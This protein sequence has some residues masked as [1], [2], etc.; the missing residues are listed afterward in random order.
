MAEDIFNASIIIIDDDDELRET[1][2]DLLVS[3]GFKNAFQAE[4]GV[5]ALQMAKK[6]KFDLIVSDLNM[7]EM[8][9]IE[10]IKKIKEI[11]PKVI[12]MI[13][14]GFGNMD[15]AIKAFSE[16]HINDFLSKPVENDELLE[17]IKSHLSKMGGDS[18]EAGMSDMVR[19]E[20]GNQRNYFGQFLIDNGFIA[21]EDLLEALQKQ[22]DTGKM[23]GDTLVEMGLMTADSLVSALSEQKGYAIADDKAMSQISEDALKKVPMDYAR[24]H[25]LIPIA[26][27][28][29]GLKVAMVN[30]DDLAVTD[31]LKMIA[32]MSIIPV[33]S[34]KEKID[35][36]IDLFYKKLESTTSANS[37]LS[38]IFAEGDAGIEEVNIKDIKDEDNPDSAPII[39]LVNSILAKADLDGSSDIHIE[40]QEKYVQIRFRKDGDLYIPNGYERLPK[41]LQSS[42]AARIKVLT[43]TMKLDI[44]LRPQDGKIR[45]KLKGR[46]IDFRVGTLPTVHGEKIVL[47]LLKTEELYPIEDI[48]SKNSVFIELFIKNI[49][50]QDGI[51][52]V[53]GPTGSGKTNTLNSAVNYIKNVDI[54]IVEVADPVEIQNEGI[55]QVNINLQQDVTFASAL[56]QILR[57]DPDV[58][59]IGEMR[60][61]ETAHIGCE[62]ALTGHLVFST[63]HTNDAPSTVTRFIEMGIKDYL[64]GTV[65]RLILAQRLGRKICKMCKKEFK[66]EKSQLIGLGLTEEEIE[67]GKFYKGEGCPNCKGKGRSGRVALIEMMEMNKKISAAVMRGA[68]ALEIGDIAKAEGTYWTLREDAIRHFKAGTIDYEEALYYSVQN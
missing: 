24:L 15:V 31:N 41:K 12:S 53:T 21:E 34:T 14:T 30:P 65:I 52:L 18:S 1:Y 50:K 3:E 2:Y 61:F 5:K 28:D 51:I 40:P 32:Q 20:F 23:L 16:S 68:T 48:F 60:D 26:I 8:D 67:N 49:K 45:L 22:K 42:L 66:Y 55:N 54:N 62:A 9:G 64:I 13:L 6:Q 36:A 43:K 10:T 37:A 25:S 11:H 35:K 29:N 44:K 63:L 7:P 27:E 57:Q 38:E 47:R 19:K 59:L 4:T 56:R 33:Y 17:K 39:S 46:E 58:I